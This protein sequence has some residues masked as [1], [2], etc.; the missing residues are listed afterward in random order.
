M[1]VQC[2]SREKC[3][4]FFIPIL[5]TLFSCV[6]LVPANIMTDWI[7]LFLPVMWQ[8]LRY[9]L[10]KFVEWFATDFGQV[11]IYLSTP[12]VRSWWNQ[13]DGWWQLATAI[14][15][16]GHGLTLCEWSTHKV[17]TTF[18][19]ILLVFVLLELT[20]PSKCFMREVCILIDIVLFWFI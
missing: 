8:K 3:M 16:T 19:L 7:F 20:Q 12:I 11:M 14:H 13:W 10:Q 1:C 9:L 2:H 4:V 5:V 6:S 15:N 17:M 18:I